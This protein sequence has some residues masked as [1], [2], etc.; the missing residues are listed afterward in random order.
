MGSR[1]EASL[2]IGSV[3]YPGRAVHEDAI[4]VD[5][6]PFDIL[7]IIVNDK[8]ITGGDQLEIAD[9]GKQIRLH[10]PKF[11]ICPGAGWG[12]E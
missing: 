5:P 11:H 9:V 4:P 6:S 7:D 8:T 2:R 3:M 12:E 10:D 1:C